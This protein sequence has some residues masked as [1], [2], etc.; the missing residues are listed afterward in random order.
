M[1]L[2]NLV[3]MFEKLLSVKTQYWFFKFS[4][5][6]LF[7]LYIA[8]LI[9]FK[10]NISSFS[11]VYTRG[12]LKFKGIRYFGLFFPQN[13]ISINFGVLHSKKSVFAFSIS[14]LNI[15]SCVLWYISGINIFN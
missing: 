8:L 9:N 11:S 15:F 7:L 1:L 13:E 5:S 10:T 14:L 6:S 12:T 4:F 2:H 3:W